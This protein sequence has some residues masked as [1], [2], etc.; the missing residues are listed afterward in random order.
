MIAI[1][2]IAAAAGTPTPPSADELLSNFLRAACL[3]HVDRVEA[4]RNIAGPDWRTRGPK[5][6]R[7]ITFS[8]DAPVPRHDMIEQVW[9][10]PLREGRARIS[11][12][13]YDFADPAAED[14]SSAI[15]WLIPE[16]AVA[17]ADVARSFGLEMQPN[18][19]R[20]DTPAG[21]RTYSGGQ[22]VGETRPTGFLQHY[23]VSGA[24]VDPAIHIEAMREW[25]PGHPEQLWRFGCARRINIHG[26]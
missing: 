4:I 6:E 5:I 20:H 19:P 1:L 17:A 12:W 9:E 23:E 15:V 3:G 10:V 21:I 7:D 2:W 16:N 24:S 26:R 8:V 25:G 13:K 18:G 14:R 22:I 11:V